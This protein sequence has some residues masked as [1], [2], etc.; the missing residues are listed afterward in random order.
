MMMESVLQDGE[1]MMVNIAYFEIRSVLRRL[2]GYLDEIVEPNLVVLG[3]GK[4]ENVLIDRTT[5]KVVGLL[6]L[7]MA[8]WGDSAMGNIEGKS[9]ARSLL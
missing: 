5:N 3:L 2:G 8:V 6:D 4:P 7:S 1:D 9:D